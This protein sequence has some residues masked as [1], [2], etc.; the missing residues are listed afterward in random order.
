MI[1]K[2]TSLKSQIKTPSCFEV[3]ITSSNEVFKAFQPDMAVGIR[4]LGNLTHEL[5][6]SNDT[7]KQIA[8]S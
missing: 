2:V 6:E 3:T 7:V 8:G 1:F 5:A 4:N